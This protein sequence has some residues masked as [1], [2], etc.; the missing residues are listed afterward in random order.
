[1]L[2]ECGFGD[3]D[4]YGDLQGAPYDQDAKRLVPVAR[5]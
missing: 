4:V 3:V 1:M 5:R 2:E